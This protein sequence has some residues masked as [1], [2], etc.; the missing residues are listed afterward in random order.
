MRH[1]GQEFGLVLR[2]QRELFRLLLERR[3]R[4]F[5]FPVFV[6]DF[7][8]LPCEE[9]RLLLEFL[10]GLL[11]FLLLL[12]QLLIGLLQLVL[13]LPEPLLR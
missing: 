13:L 5:D 6:F 4:Q 1:V 12:F 10:V 11:Q 8:I 9:L 3:A 2:C 7:L